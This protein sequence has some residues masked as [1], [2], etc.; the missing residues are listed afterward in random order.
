MQLIYANQKKQLKYYQNEVQKGKK[1]KKKEKRKTKTIKFEDDF[2]IEAEIQTDVNESN[3]N[4]DPSSGKNDYAKYSQMNDVKYSPPTFPCTFTNNDNT[5]NFKKQLE[6]QQFFAYT[7]PSMLATQKNKDEDYIHCD[8]QIS[9]IKGGNLILDLTITINSENA[10]NEYGLIE[11]GSLLVLK[12]IDKSS[13]T[14]TSRRTVIGLF[15]EVDKSVTY[16]ASYNIPSGMVKKLMTI[17]L[18]F[19]K[20]IWSTGY[21]EY[22]IF[23]TDFFINQ[24][25]CFE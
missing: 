3:P 13:I 4:Q 20:L 7:P 15:N 22:E 16:E 2:E 6:P 9:K 5:E 11:K 1:K 21:E 10:K 25:K 14:T 18:D 23:E 19:V 8:G 12:M 17:E 24:L